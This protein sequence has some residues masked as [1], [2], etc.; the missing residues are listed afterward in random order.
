MATLE[1]RLLHAAQNKLTQRPPTGTLYH[2]IH[3]IHVRERENY[4]EKGGNTFMLYISNMAHST[5]TD[6]IHVLP[7]TVAA[8]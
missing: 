5:S 8:Y 3:H 7:S 6:P 4:A 1:T 2:R